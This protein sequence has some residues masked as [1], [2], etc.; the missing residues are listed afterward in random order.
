M[1]TSEALKNL[2]ELGNREKG[3]QDSAQPKTAS[4]DASIHGVSQNVSFSHHASLYL[5]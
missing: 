4:S 5:G 3:R 2:N 1:S